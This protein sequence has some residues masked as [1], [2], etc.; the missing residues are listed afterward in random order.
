VQAEIKNTL[1][2]ENSSCKKTFPTPLKA[3][4]LQSNPA[5]PYFACPYCLTRIEGY[6]SPSRKEDKVGHK[7]EEGKKDEAAQ[8][9]TVTYE[10]QPTCQH[11]MGYLSERS[12]KEQIPD[13]CLVCM[14]LLDCMLKKV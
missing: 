6:D 8:K 14:S 11:K 9:S 1:T 12:N 2:C 7:K 13:E 10:R 5:E 3:L 4:N